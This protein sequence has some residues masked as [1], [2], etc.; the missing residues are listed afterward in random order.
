MVEEEVVAADNLPEAAGVEE[1]V[2]EPAV[3]DIAEDTAVPD[4][5]QENR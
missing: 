4:R 2:A 5:L 3:V 1:A